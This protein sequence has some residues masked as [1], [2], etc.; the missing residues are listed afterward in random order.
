MSLKPRFAEAI[1]D[2]EKTF[3]FRRALFRSLDVETVVLYAS[4]PV[5]M[6]LGEFD[7]EEVITLE[8][9]E[10]WNTTKHGGGIDR[11]YF[12][13]YFDG[14]DSGHALKVSRPLRYASPMC[15][16]EDFGLAR[17]PQSFQY[18]E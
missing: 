12:D 1:L 4:S 9:D 10:L 3:E 11:E 5:C 15:L 17:P 16:R 13:E 14:R 6:V 7:L 8:L 18:L 2:G